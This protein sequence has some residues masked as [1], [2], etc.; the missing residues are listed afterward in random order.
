MPMCDIYIQEGALEAQAEATLVAEV[1]HLLSTHEVESIRDLGV[2]DDI[3]TRVQRAESIAWMFVHRT[4]TY[5]AGQ[6]VGPWA[7]RGPVYKFEVT[8][9]EGMI[10][11]EYLSAINRDILAALTKAENGRW[12][13]PE[14]RL[15]VTTREVK[16][17]YW[18]A[19]GQPFPLR[20][21]VNYVA[22]GWGDAAVERMHETKRALAENPTET[23]A[24][25]AKVKTS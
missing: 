3:E 19:A 24:T 10:Y 4:D 9:P 17:G 12:K 1:S 21:V 16:D 5:V 7:P 20:S 13:H 6:A 8:I 2:G 11:E 14:L 15:W 18:G 25:V 23:M 22:P